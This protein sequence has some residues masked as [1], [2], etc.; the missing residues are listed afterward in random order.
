MIRVLDEKKLRLI[1]PLQIK[2]PD[3]LLSFLIG[4]FYTIKKKLQQV[5][6]SYSQ[7][8]LGLFMIVYAF[9]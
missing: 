3:L 8:L 9:S 1:T 7:Q 6:L 2:Q 5:I 4:S